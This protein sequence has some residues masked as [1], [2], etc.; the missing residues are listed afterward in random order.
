MEEKF[1]E[2]II[3]FPVKSCAPV[4]LIRVGEVVEVVARGPKYDRWYMITDNDWR[5]LSQRA[6]RDPNYRQEHNLP[7]LALIRPRISDAHL[8]LAAPGMDDISIPLNYYRGERG[9]AMIHADKVDVIDQGRIVGRWLSRYLHR[10]GCRLVRIAPDFARF[11]KE[12]PSYGQVAFADSRPWHIATRASLERINAYIKNPIERVSMDCFRP[13]LV[14]AGPACAPHEEDHW[15]KVQIGEV[16]LQ[17]QSLCVRCSTPLVNQETGVRGKEPLRTLAGLP[18]RVRP[19]ADGR[20]GKEVV[21]GRNFIHAESRGMIR[22][23]DRVQVLE[24]D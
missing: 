1:V 20:G 14:I 6:G 23:G 3:I 15:A 11:V 21:F 12:D 2:E 16:T 19:K 24:W 8:T 4:K 22:V 7:Q 5:F 13:N 18:D 17:G 9:V 10:S